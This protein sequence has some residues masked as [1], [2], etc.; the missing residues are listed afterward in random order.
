[1]AERQLAG[2]T[3]CAAG[4][5]VAAGAWV[6]YL[7]AHLGTP[8]VGYSAQELVVLPYGLGAVVCGVL[9]HTRRPGSS[10]GWM[11]LAFGAGVVL[12]AAAKAVVWVEQPG[13]AVRAV[14]LIL[15]M[16]AN[17]V[18]ETVWCTLPLWF[19]QG[20]LTRR[21]WY[22]VAGVA[23]WTTP[24]MFAYA[25]AESRLGAPNPLASGW[26]GAT[27]AVLRADLRPY[28]EWGYYLLFAGAT[29]VL[30]VRLRSGGTAWR[31]Q[32][33][34]LLAGC[35]VMF[36]GQ[37]AYRY[38]NT[39]HYWTGFAL[40]ALGSVLWAASF[41]HLV[42]R[43]GSWRI[44]RPAR[45][46]LAG[47][48][49]TTLLT[50]AYTAAAALLAT[51]MLFGEIADALLLVA[52]AFALGTGLPRA[53]AWAAGVVD[54]LFYGD[55]A[56]P[57]QVLGTLAERMNRAVR[58]QEIPDTL[59]TT[60]M[61]SLRLPG[62]ALVVHTRAGPR[63][64]ARAGRLGPDRLYVDLLH[65]GTM[66]GR[67]TVSPRE[68]EETLDALDTGILSSLAHQAAPALASL[69]LQEELQASREQIVTA[70]E[71]ERRHLRRDIHDGL[72]PTLA[73]IRL[74]VENASRQLCD[75]DPT[76]DALH[77]ISDG[78][79]TA[80]TEVRSITDR[81]GPAP[82]EELGLTAALRQLA[83]TFDGVHTRV[84]VHLDPDQLPPLPAAVEVA[85]YRIAAEAL[86]NSVRHARAGHVRVRVHVDADQLV[87]TVRDDGI[88]FDPAPDSSGVGVRS[89]RDRAAEIGGRC[90]IHRMR[91]GTLVR[92]VLPRST[93]AAQHNDDDGDDYGTFRLPPSGAPA[94]DVLD[95]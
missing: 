10:A 2:A 59:C 52:L 30:L 12:S 38:L 16:L 64:L 83:C 75:D 91:R 86:N 89:M 1:M 24:R 71:E 84:E 8:G 29:A 22:Y 93:G 76:R 23:L 34:Q 69:R 79:A 9:L 27:T 48:M 88:G 53:M 95:P 85:T 90:T 19:P 33:L 41:I 92:T 56:H 61:D 18:Q 81:L 28:W 62:V 43:T 13:P 51:E 3:L 40:F 66:I 94:G 54:R 11:L 15:D 77:T 20:R 50:V 63:V 80:I 55:R 31:S 57:Y 42:V 47:L 44:S 45:R 72:G 32:I 67:I 25:G 36:A 5:V 60:V 17:V 78:L 14:V 73:G 74:Q 70:R 7:L 58:P 37:T 65:H 26:W 82:L 49:V 6:C 35:V 21:W 87:L 46:M 4:T 39:D 68:G